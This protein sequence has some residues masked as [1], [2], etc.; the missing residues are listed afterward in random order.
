MRFNK[1]VFYPISIKVKSKWAEITSFTNPIYHASIGEATN[2]CISSSSGDSSS[3][4]ET[5]E[6][7]ESRFKYDHRDVILYA[8]SLNYS[9]KDANGLKFLYEGH[10]EFCTLPMYGVIPAFSIL[11]NTVSSLKLP[12]NLQI[13]PAKILHGEHYLE[14][15]QPFKTTDTLTLKASLVDV[16]DKGS[17]AVL[18][19]NIEFLNEK[20]ERVALNQFV[21]FAV[22]S[23]GFGGKRDSDK[24][25]KVSTKKVDR[26]PDKSISERTTIDQAALYRLNGDFNPL[27]IDPNFSAVLGFDRPILHGLCTFGFAVKHVL[28]A[29][30]N[31]DVSLFKSVKVNDR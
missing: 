16:L 3:S 1:I 25:V 6:S 7:L 26:K 11:Y 18:V 12:D 17:G 9:T 4:S 22:G 2:H 13:N 8:L 21:T 20:Q 31:D 14:V 19:I 23:G 28:S 5:G 15:F 24:M 30:C 10:P 29:Y 27:H